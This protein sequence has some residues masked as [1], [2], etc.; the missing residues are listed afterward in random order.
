VR[1]E[2]YNGEIKSSFLVLIGKDIDKTIVALEKKF[3]FV[4]VP[5]FTLKG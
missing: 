2:K 3:D 1:Y 5:K 4:N